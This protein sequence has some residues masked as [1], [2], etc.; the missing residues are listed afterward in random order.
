MSTELTIKRL[1][2]IVDRYKQEVKSASESELE[3]DLRKMINKLRR[4]CFNEI[5]TLIE[6]L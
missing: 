5:I 6:R 1:K 2:E 4:D 3:T